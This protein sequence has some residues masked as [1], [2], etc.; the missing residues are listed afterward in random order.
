VE[1]IPFYFGRVE[2]HRN[3][4]TNHTNQRN[5]TWTRSKQFLTNL[6]LDLYER[7]SC[8]LSA[9]PNLLLPHCK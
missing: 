4:T 9:R 1:L 8:T 6:T 2:V 5:S 3:V 7:F